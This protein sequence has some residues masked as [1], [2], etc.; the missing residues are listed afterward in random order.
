MRNKQWTEP[1][2]WRKLKLA[3]RAMRHA[4][5]EAEQAMWERL[6]GRRLGKAQFRRQHPIGRFIVD[7]FCVEQQVAIELD[8]PVHDE[9]KV[10]DEVRDAHLR[11]L[12]IR[13]LRVR[14]E[15]VLERIEWVIGKI[16]EAMTG[17]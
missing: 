16:K 7:F 13:T 8:G 17:K 2:L 5:T 12:G 4:P 15:D 14:N 3:A 1:K 10:E 9:R 11:E 6:R